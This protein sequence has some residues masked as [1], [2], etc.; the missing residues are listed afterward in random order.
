MRSQRRI[1]LG[2]SFELRDRLQK[3]VVV[4]KSS[5]GGIGEKARA[6]RVE[7]KAGRCL[8]GLAGHGR[9]NELTRILNSGQDFT[10][11]QFTKGETMY[12]FDSADYLGKDANSPFWMD[13]A[14][15][16]DVASKFKQGEL[17]DRQGVKNY[18]AL[19]CFNKADG[20]VQ[21]VV[22]EDHVGVK[23]TLGQATENVTYQAADGT[24]VPRALS[25][26]GGGQQVTPGLGKV[27]VPSGGQQ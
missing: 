14:G 9:V 8:K 13:E 23:S 15:Y 21:G 17:W 26:P 16:K 4:L 10:P 7:G 1:A 25:L 5:P 20:L 11:K 18:L 12:G 3:S 19:P 22:S 2:V 24:V 27:V 6:L